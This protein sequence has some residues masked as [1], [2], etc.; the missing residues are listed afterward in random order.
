MDT[1]AL[2]DLETKTARVA[3]TL[4]QRPQLARAWRQCLALSEAGANLSLEDVPVREHEIIQI[5]L[6]ETPVGENTQAIRMAEVVY[7]TILSPGY[8]LTHPGY[9]FDRAHAAGRFSSLVDIDKGGRADYPK[10]KD[11]PDWRESREMFIHGIPRLLREAGPISLK[12][13]SAAAFLSGIV[14]ERHPIAERIVMMAAESY[15]R[16]DLLMKD[17]ITVSSGSNAEPKHRAYWTLAPARA[18]S[19]GAFRAWSPSTPKGQAELM[20]GLAKVASL[21]AGRIG[22]IHAWLTR[23]NEIFPNTGR[24]SARA[25]FAQKVTESLVVDTQSIARALNCS[26]RTA[27]NLISEAEGQGVLY[28]LSQRKTYR[29][30]GSPIIH[31][32]MKEKGTVAEYRRSVRLQPRPVASSTAKFKSERTNADMD[33][34]LDNILAGLDDVMNATNQVLDKYVN[35]RTERLRR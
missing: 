17:P 18:L 29:V 10:I 3:A 35:R 20:T 8:I 14:P 13:V 25:T 19:V 4:D 1:T 30:W 16:Q 27:G 33:R 31:E 34:E 15:L 9:V 22:Q 32:M 24:G 11:D 2:L 21:E 28:C 5:L 26:T 6:G 23:L 7:R 12:S